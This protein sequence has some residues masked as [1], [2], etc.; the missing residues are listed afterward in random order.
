MAS[1]TV[2]H[3]LLGLRA[4]T[5]AA[6]GL[7]SCG[8]GSELLHGMCSP[9]GPGIKPVSPALAGG[10][11]TNEPP[12]KPSIFIQF[13]TCLLSCSNVKL[14]TVMMPR[15][16]EVHYCLCFEMCKQGQVWKPPSLD[17]K[18]PGYVPHQGLYKSEGSVCSS[19]LTVSLLHLA[20]L[21]HPAPRNPVTCSYQ[22]TAS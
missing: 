10:F 22:I 13:N 1:P 12:G 6:R 11:F 3:G 19:L 16:R 8:T 21:V 15:D 14:N 18:L 17:S 20:S 7:S 5:V 2:E 9:P 4:S